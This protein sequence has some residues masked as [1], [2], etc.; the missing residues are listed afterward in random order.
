MAT[1]GKSEA[2]GGDV[3]RVLEMRSYASARSPSETQLPEEEPE[4]L[5][6]TPVKTPAAKRGRGDLTLEELQTNIFNMMA[7]SMGELKEMI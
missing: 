1:K 7:Q 2:A 4:S 3:E 6:S 5:P